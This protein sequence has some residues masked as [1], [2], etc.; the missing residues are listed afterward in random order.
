MK[1]RKEQKK[2]KK[3]PKKMH[4]AKKDLEGKSE[5]FLDRVGNDIAGRPLGGH[6]KPPA[7]SEIAKR[8]LGEMTGCR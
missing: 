7:G 8:P 1:H 6:D 2:Q 4:D 3:V 5:L